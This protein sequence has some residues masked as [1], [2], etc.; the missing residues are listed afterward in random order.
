MY[1]VYVL[2]KKSNRELYYGYTS[3]L[4]R[5]IAEHNKDKEWDIVYYEAYGAEQDARTRELKLKDYGQS[6]NH[7][8]KRIQNSLNP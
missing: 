2:Q 5:R 1:Y 3:N 4:E 7:L 6:R 8:R